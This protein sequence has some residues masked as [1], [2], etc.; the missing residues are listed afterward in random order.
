MLLDE[1]VAATRSAVNERKRRIPLDVL[2][3]EV[4]KQPPP[5]DFAAAIA[6]GGVKIIAEVKKASPSKG[7][8][9]VDFDPVVIAREYACSGAA[10]I[11]VLTEEKYF[12]GRSEYLKAIADYLGMSHPPLLC[13]D[14]IIDEYQLYE[15]RACGADAVLLIVAILTVPELISLLELARRLGMAALIEAHDET[16]VEAAVASGA[17]IIGINNRDLKTFKVD[18]AT[19]GGLRRLIPADR[20]IVSESGIVSRDDIKYLQSLGINAALVGEALMTAPDIGAKLRELS[21]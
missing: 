1:I 9:R 12:Q 11:S 21:V 15:A 14:F 16:E 18:L 13:K 7:V 8:I 3:S 6:G 20:I 4:E 19:T 5:K 2:I 10:A 17:K